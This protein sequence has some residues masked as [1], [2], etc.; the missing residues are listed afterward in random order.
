MARRIDSE[1]FVTVS[2]R[3]STRNPLIAAESIEPAA[4]VGA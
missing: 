2:E 4:F 3:R 1:G